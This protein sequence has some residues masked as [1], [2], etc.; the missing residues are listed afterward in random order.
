MPAAWDCNLITFDQFPS[1][2]QLILKIGDCCPRENALQYD[3]K[4]ASLPVPDSTLMS[5]YA[6]WKPTFSTLLAIQE[7]DVS[8]RNSTFDRNTRTS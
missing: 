6:F 7:I 4:E 5:G 1:P 2:N 3:C 8:N